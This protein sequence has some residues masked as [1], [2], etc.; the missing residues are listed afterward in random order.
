MDDDAAGPSP[1]SDNY[2][3]TFAATTIQRRFRGYRVRKEY[4]ER[5]SRICSVEVQ[6][7]THHDAAYRSDVAARVIQTAWRAFRNRRIY[8]YYRDLIRFRERGDP[9][10]LLK[11]INPR[12]A[13]LV[14]AASG[15]HVRFRLGGTVFPPLVF[16]KIFTHR[17][18][19]D[20]GAFG[21]RDY[22]NEVRMSPAEL[23]N[24]RPAQQL[25]QQIGQGPAFGRGGG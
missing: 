24:N 10:E 11:V 12:E 20:I 8:T 2:L 5:R 7:A 19:T 17:P 21:P 3:A 4:L 15:I 23:H 6:W 25:G 9:R 14:D 13:Q 16:Y 18:V 22:A 1:Y